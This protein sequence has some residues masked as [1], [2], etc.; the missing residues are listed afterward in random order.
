MND[1]SL[2]DAGRFPTLQAEIEAA[3][4]ILSPALEREDERAL[5][6]QKKF[7]A[8]EL[9]IIFGSVLAVG[10]ALGAGL[11]G[12]A[13]I[14]IGSGSVPGRHLFSFAELLLTA[15]LGALAFV[16]RGLKWQRKWLR[17]RWAAETL[18]AE[19][20]LFV[21][22]LGDYGGSPEPERVLRQRIV[23]IERMVRRGP[24]SDV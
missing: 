13:G 1:T 18:R 22:R 7:R 3:D 23:E 14:S 6:F 8:A 11:A 15:G 20:Y 4:R 16:S 17:R 10:L 24:E 12:Q 2:G 5:Q 9:A 21:G 19:R